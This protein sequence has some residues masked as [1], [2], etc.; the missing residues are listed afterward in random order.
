[1][2]ILILV[3]DEIV[4]RLVKNAL[5]S[6]KKERKSWILE[7]FPRTKVIFIKT[8]AISMQKWGFLPDCFFILNSDLKTIVDAIRE[9]ILSPDYATV[10]ALQEFTPE[11]IENYIQLTINNYNLN[12]KEIKSLNKDFYYELDTNVPFEDLVETMLTIAHVKVK[13]NAPIRMPRVIFLGP[14]GKC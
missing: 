12:I 7:G 5:E 6:F 11:A 3:D 8:Q 1:M 13:V 14:P 4:L 10:G 2:V 9:K